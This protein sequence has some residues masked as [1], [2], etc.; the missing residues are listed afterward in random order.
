MAILYPPIEII[1]KRKPEA[2]PGERTLLAFLLNAYDDEYEIFFQP[3]LNGDLPDIIVMHK[4]GGVM[5]FEVKDWDL[6]NYHVNE[7]GNW[8]VNCNNSVYKNSPLNQVLKY[9]KN[10]YD[11]HIDSL[12]SLH[13][14]D[15]KYWYVVKCAVYFHC[16][17]TEYAQKFCEGEKPSDK[18]KTFLSKNFTIIGHDSLGKESMDRI[19]EKQW[20]SK[21]NSYFTEEL[22]NSFARILRPSYHTIEEGLGYKLSKEQDLLAKSEEG[23]R[24]R[25]KGVAGSGKTFVLG[26]IIEVF[27][28]LYQDRMKDFTSKILAP[29]GK[30]AKV[31]QCATGLAAST[32]HR[33][34]GYVGGADGLVDEAD[35]YVIDETSMVDEELLSTMLRLIPSHARLIFVGDRNQLPSIGAGS[36]LRDI[37]ESGCVPCINLNVV[38]RQ[39]D[40]S[41]ILI[42]ANKI[43]KGI[44]IKT[45]RVNQNGDKGNA[46]VLVMESAIQAREQILRVVKRAGLR[47]FHQDEIQVICPQKRGETGTYV[48]NLLIQK[49]IN[50]YS[51]EASDGEDRYPASDELKYQ[52]TAGKLHTERL[53]FQVNDRVI[54][55]KNDYKMEWYREDPVEG[56]RLTGR[57][58]IVNGE[59][60]VIVKIYR[61]RDAQKVIQRIAVRY[62]SGYLIYEGNKIK[63]L[64]HAYAI[65]IHRAQGSQWPIVLCP[66]MD[67]D[68]IMLN[69][70]LLYTMYTRAQSTFFLTGSHRAIMR[71]IENDM[72][73]RR[74]TM[75]REELIRRFGIEK[76]M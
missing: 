52:D 56:F 2:T 46:Y 12:L 69:R 47:R 51:P 27:Q 11:L 6:S 64:M 54:H 16:H 24:K 74:R 57:Q 25:I 14:K 18:Y 59:T 72:P 75:L 38:K 42:N 76:K 26:I 19:F 29:T 63:E 20:I 33:F 15:Y 71:G 62:E 21:K 43:L 4:G 66:I 55:I 31:A 73:V 37:I 17:T 50:P 28:L 10:L 68:H 48:M 22:Y 23:A 70:Q 13:L 60:G 8:I 58:G 61:T 7:K 65:T 30:A 67:R 44:P 36:C 1:R 45:E 32:I 9:K 35:L 39:E 53:Y 41:G 40:S 3:F 49:A 5:I 34:V